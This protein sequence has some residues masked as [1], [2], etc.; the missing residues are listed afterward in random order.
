MNISTPHTRS[1]GHRWVQNGWFWTCAT[2]GM[3]KRSVQ[4]GGGR[5]AWEFQLLD[6][7]R[8]ISSLRPCEGQQYSR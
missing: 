3:S 1:V 4:V 6:S 7:K 5:Q 2:C 8:W